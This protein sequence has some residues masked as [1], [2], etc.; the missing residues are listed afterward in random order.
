M[1]RSMLGVPKVG[2]TKKTDI[3]YC[4]TTDRCVFQGEGKRCNWVGRGR[5][6]ASQ[7]EMVVDDPT[8]KGEKP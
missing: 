5:K 2:G 8:T 6:C 3:R 1:R 4:G 7:R